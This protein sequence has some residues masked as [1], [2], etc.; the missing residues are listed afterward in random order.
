MIILNGFYIKKGPLIWRS[1]ELQ[2]S[3]RI[4]NDQIKEIVKQRLEP[5]NTNFFLVGFIAE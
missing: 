5:S 1:K 3:C 2:T 4:L